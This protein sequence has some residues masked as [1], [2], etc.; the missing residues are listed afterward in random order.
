MHK[1]EFQV[2][3]SPVNGI[4]QMATWALGFSLC[5]VIVVS[6]RAQPRMEGPA[7]QLKKLDYFVGTWTTVG[8]VKPG[9]M[10]AGGTVIITDDNRW[11][12]G[13]R[14]LVSHSKQ[15]SAVLGNS[16]GT[17]FMGYN[18]DTNLYTYDEHT[19]EGEVTHYTGRVEGDTWTW[20]GEQKSGGYVVQDRYIMK[21]LTPTSYTLRYDML[22]NGNWMTV[23][24]GKATKK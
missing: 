17:S 8:D 14:V 10:G 23:V 13:G 11:M 3:N 22:L 21:I 1:A 12:E 20:S 4:K 24:E 5:V 9:P 2:R 7:P 18:S 16:S 6:A 15:Q 19:S